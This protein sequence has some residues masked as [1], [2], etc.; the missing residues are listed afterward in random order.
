M[1]IRQYAMLVLCSFSSIAAANTDECLLASLKS[2]DSE[3]SVGDILASCKDRVAESSGALTE[4]YRL[5]RKTERDPWVITPHRMNYI[6]PVTTTDDINRSPYSGFEDRAAELK[7]TEIKYQ[8]SFKF[9]VSRNNLLLENDGI[10]FGF[11]MKSFWQL[12][13]SEI[14][15]PFRETNYRPEIFYIAPTNW[16]L[17]GG[18]T[19]FQLG[20]EHESNGQ[21]GL[22][23]RSWNRTYASLIYERGGLAMDLRAWHRWEE[24]EPE[25]GSLDGDENPGITD[26]MGH[27]EMN[28]AYQFNHN[29]E[30]SM[31]LR[32]NFSTN[33]G[34]VEMG[35]TFPL[36]GKFKGY[37]QYF[38]GYGESLIDYDHK[39][40][41]IGIGF[42]LN[43]R[44]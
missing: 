6:L 40:R 31:M 30:A 25:P 29:I 11:T 5:E 28:A 44:L 26:Y 22:L 12:Y 39:Q 16:H 15:E 14:S 4:R 13:A 8:L 41:R 34:A 27:W 33:K 1:N 23:S 36:W 38:E 32:R 43:D 7:D 21:V 24:D 35:L 42:A 37:I 9:P 3:T 20:V 2:A 10:Y 17:F 18:N 19:G